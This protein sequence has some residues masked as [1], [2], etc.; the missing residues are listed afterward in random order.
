MEGL[1][2]DRTLGSTVEAD[3][4]GL[5]EVKDSRVVSSAEMLEKLGSTDFDSLEELAE[6]TRE[7]L[8]GLKVAGISALEGSQR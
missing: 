1:G 4:G 3:D 7:G 5:V 8:N 2:I 6:G